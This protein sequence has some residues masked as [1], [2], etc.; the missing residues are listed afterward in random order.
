VQDQRPSPDLDVLVVTDDR[1]VRDELEYGVPAGAAIDFARDAREAWT[2]LEE[3]VPSAV[4]VDLQAG[5]AGGFALARDMSYDARFAD[6]PVAILVERDQDGWLAGQAGA[7]LYRI[8]P[9]EAGELMR[10]LEDL[11]T[12]RVP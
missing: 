12:R 3:R 10:D 9:V 6:I 5:S 7:S 8:K 1:S 2:R 11:V 4:V